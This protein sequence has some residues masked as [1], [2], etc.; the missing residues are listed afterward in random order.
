MNILYTQ[1]LKWEL[2]FLFL[3]EACRHCLTEYV[4]SGNRGVFTSEGGGLS[5][6]LCGTYVVGRFVEALLRWK[7]AV[8]YWWSLVSW[9]S[10]A[11]S[12][13]SIH[14]AFSH[15]HFTEVDAAGAWNDFFFVV[16]PISSH[17][18][19]SSFRFHQWGSKVNGPGVRDWGSSAHIFAQMSAWTFPLPAP[20]NINYM[21]GEKQ[22]VQHEGACNQIPFSKITSKCVLSEQKVDGVIQLWGPNSS[23]V[24]ANSS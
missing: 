4:P 7:T 11:Q 2:F 17:S 22:I 8:R 9:C 19:S 16:Q 18:I 3:R 24:N 14:K 6:F 23:S 15:L 13:L 10:N 20:K 1:S 5:E 21:K 12:T